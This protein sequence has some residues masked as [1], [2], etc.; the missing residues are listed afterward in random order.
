MCQLCPHRQQRF[1]RPENDAKTCLKSESAPP[2]SAHKIAQTFTNLLVH[3]LE[4]AA[5]AEG[6]L[7]GRRRII[8]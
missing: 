8:Y 7:Y 4:A 1:P 2:P 6:R 3:T 5:A